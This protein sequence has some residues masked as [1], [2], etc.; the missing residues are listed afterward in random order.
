[1][2][3]LV[4]FM[5]VFFLVSVLVPTVS[6]AEI[7]RLSHEDRENI[8]NITDIVEINTV[9]RLPKSVVSLCAEKK[10]RMLD[11]NEEWGS[12]DVM[13]EGSRQTIRLVWAVTGS[14]YA[15]VHYE[16]GGLA[17]SFHVL[18]AAINPENGESSLVWKAIGGKYANF[19]EFMLAFNNNDLDDSPEYTH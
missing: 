13:M 9:K 1:M 10:G 2:R 11:P 18:V 5:T 19:D 16:R 12:F 3:C 14:G 6:Y 17:R 8:Q 4:T 15:V 7:T